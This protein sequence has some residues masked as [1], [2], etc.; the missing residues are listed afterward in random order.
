MSYRNLQK[1]C[2][3]SWYENYFRA[4]RTI[5]SQNSETTNVN[6][7]IGQD[8]TL[9]S[10]QEVYRVASESEDLTNDAHINT[11]NGKKH[12]DAESLRTPKWQMKHYDFVI[13]GHK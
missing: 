13:L 6:N 1:H 4:D 12:T 9:C 2:K 11:A 3:S 7:R 8:K 10:R 5:Q